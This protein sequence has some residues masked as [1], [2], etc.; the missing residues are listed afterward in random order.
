MCSGTPEISERLCVV[1]IQAEEE[2][3]DVIIDF[4]F[5]L[6][7]SFKVLLR[8]IYLLAHCILCL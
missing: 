5:F 7:P 3:A 2:V 1:G 6:I 4:L 8:T